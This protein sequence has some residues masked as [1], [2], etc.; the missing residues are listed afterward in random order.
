[1]RLESTTR[2]ILDVADVAALASCPW[3]LAQRIRRTLAG[4]PE[5]AANPLGA[6]VRDLRHDWGLRVLAHYSTVL[7]PWGPQN[8]HGVADIADLPRATTS[9]RAGASGASASVTDATVVWGEALGCGDVE[10]VVPLSVR[11]GAGV[12][13]Q[14]PHFSSHVRERARLEVGGL[15]WLAQRCG[16]EPLSPTAMLLL[17][18]G[19]VVA[20]ETAPAIAAFAR[21]LSRTRALV[22]QVRTRA[23][24]WWQM[25]RVCGSCPDCAEAIVR[26]DDVL[27][28]PGVGQ[29][30][31]ADLAAQGVRTRRELVARAPEAVGHMSLEIAELQLAQASAKPGPHGPRVVARVDRAHPLLATLPDAAPGDVYLDFENDSLWGWTRTDH[32]GLVYLA[33]IL[34]RADE[35]PP[36]S[37]A[38][39]WAP[40]G[41]PALTEAAPVPAWESAP[42]PE[43]GP[44]ELA[45]AAGWRYVSWWAHSRAQEA[46]LARGLLAWL[47]ARR[48]AYP[49]MR[50][51]HY[52]KQDP[53]YLKRLGRRHGLDSAAVGALIGRGGIFTDLFDVVTAAVRTGQPGLTLKDLEPLYMGPFHRGALADGAHS[54]VL[55]D[56][57][58][59]QLRLAHAEVP[60][61]PLPPALAELAAYNE[62]D[63]VSTLLLHRW[64]RA[65]AVTQ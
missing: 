18:S 8:R 22:A 59:A 38:A 20:V 54:V 26:H 35:G 31:R 24:G 5:P 30:L 51:Y 23:P 28:V 39:V 37:A 56:E 41:T 29:H 27:A 1:M 7:G 4:A 58:S 43:L 34:M 57:A 44:G 6:H 32:T 25:E 14:V 16:V 36:P 55:Y 62:Y 52:S 45:Q 65:Q 17:A 13:I 33:G 60:I 47:S 64:L 50:V 15:A 61:H 40:A 63:C 11:T 19:R 49:D 10:G 48:L 12:Q 46:H 53:L 42:A 9:V 21:A 2:L 3:R